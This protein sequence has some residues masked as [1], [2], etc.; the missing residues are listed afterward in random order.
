MPKISILGDDHHSIS[1]DE[2]SS[3]IKKYDSPSNPVFLKESH[4]FES[5]LIDE[6]LFSEKDEWVYDFDNRGKIFTYSIDEENI[7]FKHYFTGR[8][9]ILPLKNLNEKKLLSNF[10]RRLSPSSVGKYIPKIIH[11][12]WLDESDVSTPRE[13][14]SHPEGYYPQKY[15]DSVKSIIEKHPDFEIKVWNYYSVRDLIKESFDKSTLSSFDSFKKIISKCDFA[16][17]CVVYVFGGVYVD[18]DFYFRDTISTLFGD[19][20]ILLWREPNEHQYN[21]YTQPLISNGI[22]ASEKENR[23]IYG[24]IEQMKNNSSLLLRDNVLI[25]TGP[26]GL[27]KFYTSMSRDKRP[28]LNQPCKTLPFTKSKMLSEECLDCATNPEKDIVAYTLWDE[29]TGWDKKQLSAPP[30]LNNL[31]SI[32]KKD[33]KNFWMTVIIIFVLFVLIVGSVLA[34]YLFGANRKRGVITPLTT[35]LE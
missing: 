9:I 12:M 2:E 19:N 34:Y 17:M 3:L 35:E 11:L 20:K 21:F 28:K 1:I 14:S 33:N 18:L 4:S 24:W 32:E 5:I 15:S 29:G 26:Q 30:A 25:S 7:T 8:E 22:F 13:N 16:R 27:G 6:N 31:K 10:G 23:F